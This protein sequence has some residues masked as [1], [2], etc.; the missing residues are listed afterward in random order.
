MIPTLNFP[1]EGPS[2]AVGEDGVDAFG[3]VAA[4]DDV[5][6]QPDKRATIIEAVN[7]GNKTLF[8][9]STLNFI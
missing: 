3:V 7:V 4:G 1:P 8:L 6:L 9:I 2:A 5:L